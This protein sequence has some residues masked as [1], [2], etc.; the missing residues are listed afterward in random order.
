MCAAGADP[1][2]RPVIP[3]ANCTLGTNPGR[4][5]RFYQDTPAVRFGH[6]LSYTSW[7]YKVV[8]GPTTL[9]L[10]PLR[11]AL[12]ALAGHHGPEGSDMRRGGGEGE[13]GGGTTTVGGGG[14]GGGVGGGSAGGADG[15][16]GGGGV[17]TRLVR[18]GA[19]G[20]GADVEGGIEY[21]YIVNVTNT[22]S[23]DAD[24]VVRIRGFAPNPPPSPSPS[25]S[26]SPTP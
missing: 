3:S 17:G 24:D 14:G 4:T 9:S 12:A 13:A 20:M 23:I 21:E 25:P 16:G 1:Y 2:A 26:P 8:A 19:M 22:G 10:A 15:G 5:Y 7:K 18:L 6:G 11:R